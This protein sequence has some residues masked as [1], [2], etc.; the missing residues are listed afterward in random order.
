MIRDASRRLAVLA[1]VSFLA[2]ATACSSDS[3]G[4]TACESLQRGCVDL[5]NFGQQPLSMKV[6]QGSSISLPS[7]TNT[8]SSLAPGK[9]SATLDTTTAGTGVVF[10]AYNGATKV[11]SVTCTVSSVAWISVNPAAVV[12]QTGQLTCSDW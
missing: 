11:G 7:A 9:A 8:G 5:L 4:G 10:D 6:N 12:Q 1:G 3:G 2:A